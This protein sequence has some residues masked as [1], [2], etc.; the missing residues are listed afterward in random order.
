MMLILMLSRHALFLEKIA[1]AALPS[2]EVVEM[3]HLTPVPQMIHH[4]LTKHR[5]YFQYSLGYDFPSYLHYALLMIEYFLV[6]YY[7]C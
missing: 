4:H 7:H 2:L 5:Q 1:Y 3:T 6:H